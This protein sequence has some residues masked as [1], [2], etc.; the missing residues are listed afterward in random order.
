MKPTTILQNLLLLITL[1]VAYAANAQIGYQVTLLDQ[2]TGD[3]RTNE[4]VSV[5]VTLSDNSGN[6]VFSQ[7]QSVTSDAYGTLSLTVGNSST[8]DNVDWSKLPFWITASVDGKNLGRTQVL[9]VPVAEYAKRT[10]SLTKETLCSKTWV[11]SGASYKL[12]FYQDGHAIKTVSYNAPDDPNY[13]TDTLNYKYHIN[14]NI[15]ILLGE[16]VDILLYVP[17]KEILISFDDHLKCYK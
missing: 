17:D 6:T 12:K 14:G 5:T 10:G 7:T 9:S 3:P 16:A 11:D 15:I 2:K 13:Y 4:T 1:S 8:F